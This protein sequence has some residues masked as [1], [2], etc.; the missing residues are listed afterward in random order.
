MNRPISCALTESELAER[1][2]TIL[3]SLR[4]KVCGTQ[5]LAS[6]FAYEFPHAPEVALKIKQ[7]VDLERECCG[8]LTFNIMEM[9]EHIRLE[10]TGPMESVDL[11]EDFFGGDAA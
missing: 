8:F 10:I 2:R 6:G 9:E 1:R 4:D 11:I 5:R 3:I 7:A